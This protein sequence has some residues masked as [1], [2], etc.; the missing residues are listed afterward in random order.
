[1]RPA[2]LALVLVALIV[3]L[4]VWPFRGETS[5]QRVQFVRG[6][7]A[8]GEREL[9]ALRKLSAR[10]LERLVKRLA[11]E[12]RVRRGRAILVLAGDTALIRKRLERALESGSDTVLISERAVASRIGMPPAKQALRNNCETTALSMLLGSAGERVGQLTL[13]RRLPRSGP[14]DP[15]PEADGTLVWGD[16]G[17]GF[18]GRA[19]GGGPAGGFGVYEGP[20]KALATRYEVD[21]T[22][23]TSASS[24]RLYKT[25]LAGRP[26]MA[27]VG[28]SDGPYRT[29]KTPEG[30]TVS[31]NFG[32]HT[33]VLTGAASGR[34]FV[35]DPLSGK[36]LRWT[37]AEFELMWERLG[38]RA[39]SL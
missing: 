7:V 4:A 16:P 37:R 13:Q 9:S 23:L 22:D 11:R 18:V 17:R 35:N 32:E 26:V 20:I 28:L 21:L 33:V 39:L 6:G 30:R 38:R 2:S 19:D 24:H 14:L 36:R 15:R 5:A 12:R 27:W 1:M 34:V 29:W 8:I 31:V 10:R 25:L 3:T